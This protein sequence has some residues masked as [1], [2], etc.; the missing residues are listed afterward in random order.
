MSQK[1]NVF[2]TNRTKEKL[3]RGEVVV[4][5][6][7]SDSR[8]T[9]IAGL[10]GYDFVRFEGEHGNLSWQQLD[11]LVAVAHLT[12]VTPMARVPGCVQHEILYYCDNGVLGITVPH[13]SSRAVAEAAVRAAKYHPIGMRGDNFGGKLGRYGMLGY[14]Q[15]EYYDAV[16]RAT[17]VIALIEDR[18][19]VE[20][21]A[22]IV[23]TPGIDAVDIGNLDLAQSMGLPDQDEVDEAIEHIV[24]V[25][26]KAGLPV[27]APY[28]S[29]GRETIR[30]WMEKG[31]RIFWADPA[32]V[33][34]IAEN[35]SV[36]YT[37]R[38]PG[39][40]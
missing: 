10:R 4:G 24:R 25:T 20:N 15:A 21:I 5:T 6:G 37:S 1:K 11:H 36:P 26:V 34:E 18:E 27:G 2:L 33:Y 39:Q 35:L 22:E 9:D 40:R 3:L 12:G 31:C 14:T 28:L 13:T 32:M 7:A 23:A 30:Y 17:M 8:S 38:V 29:R 19:G 16:N